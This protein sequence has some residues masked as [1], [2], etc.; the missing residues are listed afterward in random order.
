MLMAY[1]FVVKITGVLGNCSEEMLSYGVEGAVFGPFL[2]RG[3]SSDRLADSL[4]W[5]TPASFV[6]VTVAL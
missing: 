1:V 3:C 2:F 6:L 5:H 4:L